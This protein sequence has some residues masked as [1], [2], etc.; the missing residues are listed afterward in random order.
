[1]NSQIA[2]LRERVEKELAKSLDNA[3]VPKR[4]AQAMRY[5]TLS[6]GKRVRA[7]LVYAAGAAVNAPLK[8]LDAVATAIECIHAYS[9]IHDDLPAMDNDDLR[10]GQAT[11]HI[12][13]DEATAILAGDAL[14]TLAFELIS[15]SDLDDKQ[16][17]TITL[18]LS[19]SAGQTGMVGGQMLDIQATQQTLGI[20]QLEDI[21]RRKTGALINASVICGALCADSNESDTQARLNVYAN[22]LGLAFQVVDDILDIEGSTAEL[23]KP[24]GSDIEHGKATYPALIGLQKSKKLAETL[25]Q[26]AIESISQISDNTRSIET[27][28]LSSKDSLLQD[29]ATLVIKR[30]N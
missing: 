10:R 7:L 2:A 30:T 13:F 25:Y 22:K 1:L 12:E 20:E 9:L 8:K 28:A 17:R 16:A 3:L 4:L 24:K 26:E 19:E 11:N 14:L 21:H 6:T 15:K 27:T 5:S 18:K 23:G 29:L